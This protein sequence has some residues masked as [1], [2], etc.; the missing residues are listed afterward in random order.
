[1]VAEVQAEAAVQ[2][3]VQATATEAHWNILT[4]L[5][6]SKDASATTIRSM[7][8]AAEHMTSNG[9]APGKRESGS[10]SAIENSQYVIP[11]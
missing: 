11:Y 2:A 10:H 1:M 6:A 7:Q 4:D 3:T 5:E 8:T 9:M